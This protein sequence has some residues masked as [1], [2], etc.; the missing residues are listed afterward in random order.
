M[1]RKKLIN[2]ERGN[3]KMKSKNNKKVLIVLGI[4]IL[5][6]LGS[7]IAYFTTSTDITNLFKVG[8]YQ[9]EI[10]EEFVSPNNWVPG[11]TTNKKVEV[12]NNGSIS[13]AVR[14]SYTEKWTSAN[15]TDSPLKD[16]DNNVASIINFNTGWTK[17]ADGYYYY[18]SKT[19]MTKVESNQTTSSFISG[20]TFN[21]NIKSTL[22]KTTSA[23]GQ[24]ITYTSSGNGYDDATYTLTIK[25]DTIQYDQA[26]NVW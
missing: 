7:T 21:E 4:S 24:T 12:T 26:Q 19:N 1:K 23:D 13:M 14:A 9:H 20:V 17:D 16:G 10:V 5:T 15:G 25:I 22:T 6:V 11:T 3:S 2:D 18:G 8:L